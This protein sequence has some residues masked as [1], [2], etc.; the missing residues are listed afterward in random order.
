MN[1][2]SKSVETAKLTSSFENIQRILQGEEFA[3]RLQRPLAFWVRRTDK[4]LPLALLD[5]TIA[6]LIATPFDDLSSTPGVGQKKIRTLVRLLKRASGDPP[7]E[8]PEVVEES[9]GH[10]ASNNSEFDAA[11]VSDAQWRRWCAAIREFKLEQEKIGRIAPTLREVPTVIWHTP[12]GN[13]VNYGLEELRHLKNHG[14]KRVRVVL[15]VFHVVN[16]MI[17]EA[18]VLPGHL[19]VRVVP[20]FVATIENWLQALDTASISPKAAEVRERLMKPLLDQTLTDLGKPIRDLAAAR[21]G[22]DES[23]KTVQQLARQSA[24]TRARVYQLLDECAAMMKVRWPEGERQLRELQNSSSEKRLLD[25]ESAQLFAAAAD[26]FYPT[27]NGKSPSSSNGSGNGRHEHSVAP[28]PVSASAS[29][30]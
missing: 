20:R 4:G 19:S 29:G 3:D 5:R 22:F 10:A 18:S 8:L 13:Y 6:D 11:S 21:L 9:N 7:L 2:R 30:V 25:G 28:V 1:R 12:L 23:A 15:C 24:I 27:T 16:Q 17:S 14:E 26:L